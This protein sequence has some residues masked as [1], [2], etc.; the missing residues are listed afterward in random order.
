MINKNHINQ[1]PLNILVITS[2]Y[3]AT[4]L[5]KGQVVISK[6]LAKLTLKK[7]CI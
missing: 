6:I 3:L 7:K 4:S 2:G 1:V 5:V